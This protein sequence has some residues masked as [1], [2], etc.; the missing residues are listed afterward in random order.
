M[1]YEIADI[2]YTLK[3]IVTDVHEAT[4]SDS[5]HKSGT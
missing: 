2:E 3:V 5:V 1:E 4:G